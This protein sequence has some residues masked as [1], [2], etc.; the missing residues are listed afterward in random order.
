MIL[1]VENNATVEGRIDI[2]RL[3][4]DASHIYVVGKN[5]V[6]GFTLFEDGLHIAQMI[7]VLKHVGALLGAATC[8]C[9]VGNADLSHFTRCGGRHSLRQ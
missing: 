4:I 9:E 7:A 1:A 5:E 3:P 2:E 8:R 6:C